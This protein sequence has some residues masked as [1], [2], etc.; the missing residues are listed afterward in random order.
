MRGWIY[1]VAMS[2]SQGSKAVV[3]TI[4]RRDTMLQMKYS[5]SRYDLIDKY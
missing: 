4:G 5:R 3:V 2:R 1:V